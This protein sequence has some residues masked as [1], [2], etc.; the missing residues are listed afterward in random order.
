MFTHNKKLWNCARMSA[1]IPHQKNSSITRQCLSCNGSTPKSSFQ[2][3]VATRRHLNKWRQPCSTS[4]LQWTTSTHHQSNL[5]SSRH[6]SR[7]WWNLDLLKQL[8]S[9]WPIIQLLS[10][11]SLLALTFQCKSKAPWLTREVLR[12]KLPKQLIQ[13]KLYLSYLVFS[14]WDANFQTF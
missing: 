6:N 11:V 4:S 7:K 12:D 14:A 3:L 1:G 2:P 8:I 9:A 5:T 10:V 13:S